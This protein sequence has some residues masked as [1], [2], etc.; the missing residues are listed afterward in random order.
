[1]TQKLLNRADVVAGLKKVGGE[2]VTQRMGC[3]PFSDTCS[4]D[5]LLEGPLN[6]TGVEVVAFFPAAVRVD[7]AIYRRE[8][9]PPSGVV[10]GIRVLPCEG[11][12]K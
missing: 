1:M 12:G 2:A 8:E 3:R 11:E 7:R 4:S 6:R 10:W 9:V 5:S